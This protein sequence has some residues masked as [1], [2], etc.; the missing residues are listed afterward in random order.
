MRP[1]NRRA[2]VLSAVV[3]ASFAVPGGVPFLLAALVLLV[4]CLWLH[5]P[6]RFIWGLAIA[7]LVIAVPLSAS[8]SIEGAADRI[9]LLFLLLMSLVVVSAIREERLED[10]W[11]GEDG[12]P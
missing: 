12:T 11:A 4:T 3:A 6:W 2:V 1:G 10:G 7:S 8:T 5:A 9:T